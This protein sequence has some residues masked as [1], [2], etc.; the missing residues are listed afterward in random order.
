MP[1][2][3]KRFKDV[4]N[5]PQADMYWKAMQKEMNNCWKKECFQNTKATPF[6]ANAEILPLVWAYTNKFDKDG[7]F[8]K[9]IA[10]SP[11]PLG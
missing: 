2:P 5:H 6:T 4:A 1:E 3:P 10:Q 7:Y 8:L 11:S 9:A